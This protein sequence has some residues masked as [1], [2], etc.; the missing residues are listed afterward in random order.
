MTIITV[1]TSLTAIQ[2]LNTSDSIYVA[3]TGR[4]LTAST[5]IRSFD[6]SRFNLDVSVDGAVVSTD[7][8]PAAIL[9]FGTTT[10][11]GAAGLGSHNV[12]I[13]T[14]GVVRAVKGGTGVFAAGTANQVINDGLVQSAGAGIVNNGGPCHVL[15]SG[16]VSA[17]GNGVNL[18]GSFSRVTNTG[19]ISSSA[20]TAIDLF[21][22]GSVV[23]NRGTLAGIRGIT[24]DGDDNIV[25]NS[26]QIVADIGM[27]QDG[28]NNRFTNT[29]SGDVTALS[30]AVL[31]QGSGTNSL[32][33]AGG[34][35]GE[36]FG[37]RVRTVIAQIANHG[38]I[39]AVSDNAIVVGDTTTSLALVNTGTIRTSAPVAIAGNLGAET[40]T[41]SGTIVGDV[42]LGAGA[43]V[44]TNTGTV[45]GTVDMGDGADRMTNTDG[46]IFGSILGGIGNDT[47]TGGAFAENLQGGAGLDRIFGGGG[48]DRMTPG[49]GTDVVTGGAGADVFVFTSQATLGIGTG[50]DTVTD[51]VHLVDDFEML[52]MD[53]FIGTDPFTAAGQVRYVQATG[54]LS[55]STDADAAIEWAV[56]LVNR[57]MI[58][59][60]DFVF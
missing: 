45:R 40:I 20:E 16:T 11:G 14:T 5:A 51:F 58:T 36:I 37:V 8:A 34:L 38:V 46:R 27:E 39:E 49:A 57:P 25:L 22:D 47:L 2:N 6:N 53:A 29:S 50:R 12:H 60:D 13:G 15:N 26:G 55:G 43:D 30:I 9:L 4:I 48:D 35:M 56:L 21:G 42:R 33:N 31:M 54:L 3:Q 19:D 28:V 10:N 32:T 1:T 23:Q 7:S 41:N 59:A 44:V 24:V 18:V 52:F 17:R